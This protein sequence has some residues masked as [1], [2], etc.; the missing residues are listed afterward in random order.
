MLDGPAGLKTV[1]SDSV[2]TAEELYTSS[3]SKIGNMTHVCDK[4]GQIF[5]VQSWQLPRGSNQ[6]HKFIKTIGTW[7]RTRSFG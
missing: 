6:H 7:H 2:F 5:M 1:D 3:M 4:S